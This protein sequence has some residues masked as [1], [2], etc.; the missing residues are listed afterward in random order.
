MAAAERIFDGSFDH[1]QD[2]DQ[3]VEMANEASSSTSKV[4]TIVSFT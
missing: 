2:E 4:R 3:D 1:I